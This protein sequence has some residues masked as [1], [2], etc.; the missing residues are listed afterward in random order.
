MI[1]QS[2]FN[3]PVEVS[4]E[5]YDTN[6]QPLPF[7]SFSEVFATQYNLVIDAQTQYIGNYHI[8]IILKDTS[9]NV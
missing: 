5:C 3:Q 1:V 2:Y 7:V 9:L 6:M 8:A 4:Q